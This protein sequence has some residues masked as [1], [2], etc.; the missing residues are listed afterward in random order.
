MVNTTNR[1]ALVWRVSSDG[2][3]NTNGALT[4]VGRHF[5][6][7]K[8]QIFFIL[9]KE[10]LILLL[11]TESLTVASKACFF[12]NRD[13]NVVTH[14][15]LQFFLFVFF[16]CMQHNSI[17]FAL[18]SGLYALTCNWYDSI[19]STWSGYMTRNGPNKHTL[20]LHSLHYSNPFSTALGPS[21]NKMHP[22]MSIFNYRRPHLI[23]SLY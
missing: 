1:L 13:F 18:M 17:M 11:F 19:S 21:W 9:G 3:L 20:L 8:K 14:F 15:C 2:Y 22:T 5:N 6:N 12:F 23:F 7:I 16:F 4:H 10:W